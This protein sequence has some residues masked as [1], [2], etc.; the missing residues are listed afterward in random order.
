MKPE[1]EKGTRWP[2]CSFSDNGQQMEPGFRVR[3]LEWSLK[4]PS[5]ALAQAW[6]APSVG[7]ASQRS[8]RLFS[9]LGTRCT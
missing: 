4:G 2:H 3:A 8:G 1:E 9:P 7:A 5:P 6:K